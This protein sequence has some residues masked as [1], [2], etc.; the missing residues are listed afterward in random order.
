MSDIFGGDAEKLPVA[1]KPLD[2]RYGFDGSDYYGRGRVEARFR[3]DEEPNEPNRFDWVVA[4]DPIDPQA[5]PV[6]RS[7]QPRWSG[8]R[9]S[10]RTR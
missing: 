10:R 4:I 2:E 9:V 8:P 5:L 1:L 6:K 3:M 7:A